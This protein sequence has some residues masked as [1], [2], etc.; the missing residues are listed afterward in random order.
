MTHCLLHSTHERLFYFWN[1][2]RKKNFSNS[3]CPRP[4]FLALL[5][6]AL[7]SPFM[8]AFKNCFLLLPVLEHV[9]G[10]V[11]NKVCLSG[12]GLWT[13][14]EVVNVVVNAINFFFKKRFVDSF[15]SS[16]CSS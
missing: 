3:Q 14:F 5:H 2:G 15:R 9:G 13:H 16:K 8:L 4:T 11:P 6:R 7:P 1:K 10:R 12:S